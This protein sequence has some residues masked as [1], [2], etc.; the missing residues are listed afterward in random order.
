M[1]FYYSS[2]IFLIMEFS[3][4]ITH[5]AKKHESGYKEQIMASCSAF[6][7]KVCHQRPA[8]YE[9]MIK[10]L[11]VYC[12]DG[13]IDDDIDDFLKELGVDKK[14][15]VK[16]Q[17]GQERYECILQGLDRSVEDAKKKVIAQID[18]YLSGVKKCASSQL[19]K[20]DRS[21]DNFE[22]L[23]LRNK[24]PMCEQKLKAKLVQAI[25][26]NKN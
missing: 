24:Y 17:S 10:A 19:L 11:H 18:N 1:V 21:K 6:C 22:W 3:E 15:W 23:K 12:L 20:E 14:I 9:E 25:S 16:M 2:I 7:M 13:K 4:Q 26:D 5:I 8:N